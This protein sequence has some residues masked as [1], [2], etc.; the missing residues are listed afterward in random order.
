M[1][2]AGC[3]ILLA[4]ALT[5]CG[6]DSGGGG[7]LSFPHG[8]GS[9]AA[10]T[11]S[12][13]G[14]TY[15]QSNIS[16]RKLTELGGKELQAIEAADGESTDGPSMT[17]DVPPSLAD[18]LLNSPELAAQERVWNAKPANGPNEFIDFVCP[19]FVR[20]L[21]DPALKSASTAMRSPHALIL[22]AWVL[23]TCADSI[24]GVPEEVTQYNRD[25]VKE[26]TR[27]EAMNEESDNAIGQLAASK[28][29][30]PQFYS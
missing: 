13:D 10:P 1:I 8:A 5:D 23:G 18:S 12:A 29:I 17:F 28:S 15:P 27:D 2:A 24:P 6:G 3:A 26:I 20:H 9:N 25:R 30:C 19:Y 16:L 22:N 4:L 14:C 11:T 7:G 21:N